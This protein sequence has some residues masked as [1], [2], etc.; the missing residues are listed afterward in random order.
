MCRLVSFCVGVTNV[1]TEVTGG[2]WLSV[3]DVVGT[4]G[5]SRKTVYKYIGNSKLISKKELGKRLIWIDN[6]TTSVRM[7]PADIGG[8]GT[9]GDSKKLLVAKLEMKVE[10]L[11]ESLKV[12]QEQIEGLRGEVNRLGMLLMFEK[13]SIFARVKDYFIGSSFIPSVETK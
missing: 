6:D 4:L 8:N 2:S 1:D 12:R 13:R 3:N 5:I 11:E 10:F 7:S 9:Q